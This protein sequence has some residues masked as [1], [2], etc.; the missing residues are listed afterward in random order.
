MFSFF[1]TFIYCIPAHWIWSRKG[2]LKQLGATDMAGAGTVH[3]VGGVTGLV[4][5]IMLKPRFGMFNEEHKEIRKSSMSS[6]TNAI[7]GMFML[8]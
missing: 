7:L 8:W 6:P 5:T 1:N 4:A 3:L 2:W